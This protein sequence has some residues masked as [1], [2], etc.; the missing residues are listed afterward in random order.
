MPNGTYGGVGGGIH[1]PPTRFTFGIKNFK[2]EII[3]NFLRILLTILIFDGIL[4]LA[5]GNAEC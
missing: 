1:F 5:L 4:S 2:I 3:L